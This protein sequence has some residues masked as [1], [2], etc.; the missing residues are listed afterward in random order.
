[1]EYVKSYTTSFDHVVFT[2]LAGCSTGNIFRSIAA[3]WPSSV[4][5]LNCSFSPYFNMLRQLC[6]KQSK[7][8]GFFFFFISMISNDAAILVF[9]ILFP[10]L[11][12]SFTFC[13]SFHPTVNS[14]ESKARYTWLTIILK[15]IKILLL[16]LITV[17]L[18]SSLIKL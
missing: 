8:K 7:T 3:V 13:L 5:V 2:N 6:Q 12:V 17:C 4:E 10:S 9:I 11:K 18:C 14:G 16:L 15:K 1:M